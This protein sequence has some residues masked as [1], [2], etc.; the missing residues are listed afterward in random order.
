MRHRNKP[1]IL[2]TQRRADNA[3]LR[4]LAG[5]LILYEK[6]KTTVS[7]AKVLRIVV[8]RLITIAKKDNLHARR[9]LIAYLPKMGSV[10]KLL[11]ELVPRYK[12][13]QGGYTRIVKTRIRKGDG[14]Q[15]AQ[16]ELT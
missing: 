3:T 4:N 16:I 6:I 14:A 11:E 1:K 8:E 15:M 13:R 2:S 10:R 5:A 7:R 9:R 12:E